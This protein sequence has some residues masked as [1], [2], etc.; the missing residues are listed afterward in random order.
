MM[1][2]IYGP[3]HFFPVIKTK[4]LLFTSLYAAERLDV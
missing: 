4:A 2:M 3:G 1:W